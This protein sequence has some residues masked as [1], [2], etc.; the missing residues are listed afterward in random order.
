MDLPSMITLLEAY[1]AKD[2]NRLDIGY[3]A[4]SEIESRLEEDKRAGLTSPPRTALSAILEQ[5]SEEF[6]SY[7]ASQSACRSYIRDSVRMARYFDPDKIAELEKYKLTTSHL[8]ACI[9]GD[10]WP[11][12]NE[13]ETKVLLNWAIDNKASPSDIWDHRRQG[14]VELSDVEKAK[15]RL[16]SALTHYLDT[17]AVVLGY[18]E[19][20]KICTDLLMMFE[21][22]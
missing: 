16:L 21:K 4:L 8:L 14:E 7:H 11:E 19:E 3:A 10:T 22:G 13:E 20:R 1:A 15:R 9:R 6:A 17:T 12:C 18:T 2:R 5:L